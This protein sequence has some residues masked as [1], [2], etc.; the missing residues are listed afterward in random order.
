MFRFVGKV[1][2]GIFA[3]RSK[4]SGVSDAR[5]EARNPVPQAAA[6]RWKRS[7][8]LSPRKVRSLAR[9]AVNKDRN[10]S[11]V[12]SRR[13]WRRS[14]LTLPASRWATGLSPLRQSFTNQRQKL[15]RCDR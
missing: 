2:V 15:L 7:H 9:E 13:S 8:P 11:A 12:S 14:T 5:A 6:Y 3:S 4:L 1:T 10:S